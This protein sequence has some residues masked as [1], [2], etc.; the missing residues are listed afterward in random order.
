[1]TKID[2]E[3]SNLTNSVY[4]NT[5]KYIRI[6]IRLSEKYLCLLN[7]RVNVDLFLLVGAEGSDATEI[8]ALLVFW[9]VLKSALNCFL[10]NVECSRKS[11]MNLPQRAVFVN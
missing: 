3:T 7:V 8:M 2:L 11:L 4:S 6:S 10:S 9:G 1:M 5:I